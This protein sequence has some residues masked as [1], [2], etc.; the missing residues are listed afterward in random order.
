MVCNELGFLGARE[1]THN[2]RFGSVNSNFAMDGISC[3]EDDETLL[4]CNY[5]TSDDCGSSE[6]AG[7]VCM[8]K[9]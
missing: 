1:D 6:G 3:E 5:D 4:D 8:G 7:V 2:S 9:Y